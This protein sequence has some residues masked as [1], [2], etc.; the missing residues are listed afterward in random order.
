[1]NCA[2]PGD[3]KLWFSVWRGELPFRYGWYRADRKQWKELPFNCDCSSVIRLLVLNDQV[4]DIHQGSPGLRDTD[5][6]FSMLATLALS[7]IDPREL[8]TYGDLTLLS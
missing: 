5:N 4:L 1:M 7:Y 2:Q 3:E 6:E 8:Y